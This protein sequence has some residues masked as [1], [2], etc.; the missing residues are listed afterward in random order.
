FGKL[1]ITISPDPLTIAVYESQRLVQRLVIDK[2]KGTIAFDIS[3]GPVL[4][5]GEGGPQF[6][7][8]GHKDEMRNGQ[9]G[10]RL[11]THGGRAAI[12]W[13]I[14]TGGW[15]MFVHQP[16][17]KFDLTGDTGRFEPINQ[18]ASL[19]LNI[20]IVDARDPA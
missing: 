18:Q 10:Y 4:G 17:G 13:L 7:R 8:R 2:Q 15:A 12:P 11:R 1:R 6:D 20:L 19:P 3:A 5:L 9:G 16:I 14:G